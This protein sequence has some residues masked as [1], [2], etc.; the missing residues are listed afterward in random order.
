VND[1]RVGFFLS[2][3]IMELN[4]GDFGYDIVRGFFFLLKP[5]EVSC[6]YVSWQPYY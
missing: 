4:I 5:D 6:L 1:A 3:S 2:F